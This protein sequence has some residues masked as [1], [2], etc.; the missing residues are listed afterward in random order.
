VRSRS[1]ICAGNTSKAERGLIL[2]KRGDTKKASTLYTDRGRIERHIIPLIGKRTVKDLTTADVRKFVQDVIAGKTAGEVQTPKRRRAI[3]RGGPGAAARTKGLLGGILSYA[4]HEGYRPDNP[5]AGVV[6]PKDKTREWRL[7]DTGYR[8]LGKCL[9]RARNE[10][11]HW[12]PV[13]AVRIAALTG[14]RLREIEGLLKVDVDPARMVLRL[15]QTKTGKSIRPIGGG[16]GCHQGSF[17]AFGLQVRFSL[18][19]QRA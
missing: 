13:M 19:H 11:G 9:K 12:Q 18:N 15:Q 10:G 14:C 2:T 17:S 5:A 4:V 7:D 16:F 3:V 6:R 8:E 1:R